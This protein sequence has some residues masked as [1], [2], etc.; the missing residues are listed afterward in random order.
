[1]GVTNCKHRIIIIAVRRPHGIQNFVYITVHGCGLLCIARRV[2]RYV[3]HWTADPTNS[4]H[5]E[6]Y[7]YTHHAN[8]TWKTVT[9][10]KYLKIS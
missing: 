4:T 9:G 6:I 10:V 3:I 2:V 7:K 8:D 5:P 1:M